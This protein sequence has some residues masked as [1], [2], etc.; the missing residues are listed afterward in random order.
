M[1]NKPIT[2]HQAAQPPPGPQHLPRFLLQ[3]SRVPLLSPSPGD[4]L[5][6]QSFTH[7]KLHPDKPSITARHWHHPPA[8]HAPLAWP[9]SQG[10]DPAPPSHP[11]ALLSL[12]GLLPTAALWSGPAGTAHCH[13][14]RQPQLQRQ[15]F[16]KMAQRQNTPAAGAAAGSP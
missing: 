2:G 8:S 7:P 3:H 13:L 9:A 1:R 6:P 10:Q 15:H 16:A 11:A 5:P 4:P 14:Q 12:L